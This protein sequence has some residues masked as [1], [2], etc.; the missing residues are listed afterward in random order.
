MGKENDDLLPIHVERKTKSGDDDHFVVDFG[1]DGQLG[2]IIAAVHKGVGQSARITSFR[3]G[4]LLSDDVP[5][6]DL[7]HEAEQY[8]QALQQLHEQRAVTSVTFIARA[9]RPAA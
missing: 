4:P 8:I 3:R 5:D 9:P 1:F 6:E 7:T 2:Q